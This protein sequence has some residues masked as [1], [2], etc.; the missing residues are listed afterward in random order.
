M[1]E[2]PSGTESAP[3]EDQAEGIAD[4]VAD[5]PVPT[6]EATTES[7]PDAQID[8]RDAAAAETK[9][10]AEGVAAPV[11]DDSGSAPNVSS[12]FPVLVREEAVNPLFHVLHH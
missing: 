7:S 8:G 11:A 1:H 5:A 3:V 6:S 9:E 4:P 2:P 10:E 12:A